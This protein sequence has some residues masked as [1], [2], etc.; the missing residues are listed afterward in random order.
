MA[1]ELVFDEAFDNLNAWQ[2]SDRGVAEANCQMLPAQVSVAN[3][4]VTLTAT[5]EAYAPY[6]YRSGEISTEGI[7]H[8]TYG[9][10]EATFKSY[11]GQGMWPG[12]W[13][14]NHQNLYE[15]DVVELL[16]RDPD[17]A[18]LG[19]HWGPG[20]SQ[21]YT[22]VAPESL[23]DSWH[24]FAAEWDAA[25]VKWYVDGILRATHTQNIADQPMFAILSFSVGGAWGG[26][27]DETTVF[28][29]TMKANQVRVWQEEVTKWHG[30]IALTDLNL[31]AGQWDRFTRGWALRGPPTSTQPAYLYHTRGAT[32]EARF[33]TD[34]MT[35]DYWKEWL[36]ILLD[37]DVS[38]V[39]SSTSPA[40]YAGGTTDETT[41]THG[42]TDY[43]TVHVFGGS[44]STWQQ[45]RDEC[46][47]YLGV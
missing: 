47:G 38:T 35:I 17:E 18:N 46:A 21:V 1:L 31:S 16:G 5:D 19:Y 34:V 39:S 3:N 32:R 36:S 27:P 41:V 22:W 44:G 13:A 26:E 2:T 29:A 25:S 28:P 43:F 40:S 20:T 6:D 23:G 42:G 14:I 9:K 4:E 30:Y 33:R 8:F 11:L 24:I 15:I 45:S 7:F 37:V 12:W 10:F